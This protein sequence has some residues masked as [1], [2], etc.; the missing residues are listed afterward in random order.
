MKYP[1]GS[2]IN[3]VEMRERKQRREY[4]C[5][6]AMKNDLYKMRIMRM[7]KKGGRKMKFREVI[8]ILGKR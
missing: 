7:I 5:T 8:K 4:S 3:W 1:Y 2:I 6:L